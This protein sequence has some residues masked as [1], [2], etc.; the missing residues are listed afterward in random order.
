[1]YTPA[2]VEMFVETQTLATLDT[3]L[4]VGNSA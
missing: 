4:G 2:M 3:N 1:M